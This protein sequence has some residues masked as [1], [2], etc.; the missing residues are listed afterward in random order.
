MRRRQGV[1]GQSWRAPNLLQPGDARFCGCC[2]QLSDRASRE[3][4]LVHPDDLDRF[5][6]ICTAAVATEQNWAVEARLRCPDGRF[7]WHQLNFSVLRTQ[8]TVAAYLATATDIDDLHRLV[9]TARESE[10]QLRLAAE[11]AQLGVYVFDLQRGEHSW[12]PELKRIFGLNIDQPPPLRIVE[13]IHP[14]DRAKV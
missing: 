5:V 11:A 9:T 14:D 2:L 8:G 7:R 4:A 6:E 10:E 1:D 3:R 13:F 12:S